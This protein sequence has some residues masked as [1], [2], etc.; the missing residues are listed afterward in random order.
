MMNNIPEDQQQN[1]FNSQK[2]VLKGQSSISISFKK[3]EEKRKVLS[4]VDVK[5][6]VFEK[7]E[8]CSFEY[9]PTRKGKDED[10]ISRGPDIQETSAER[11]SANISRRTSVR[12]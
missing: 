8:K 2:D 7:D 10:K 6:L 4:N 9:D 5:R 12:W 11:H 1:M 3:N